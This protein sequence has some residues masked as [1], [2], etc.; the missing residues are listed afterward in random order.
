MNYRRGLTDVT[1]H[2]VRHSVAMGCLI[3]QRLCGRLSTFLNLELPRISS[4]V[5]K[6]DI[7]TISFSWINPFQQS[8]VAAAERGGSNLNGCDDFRTEN[9]S[10]QG[11]NLVLTGLICSKF[12]RQRVSCI[13]F[14]QASPANTI[15]ASSSLLLSSLELG[16][17]Q[18]MSLND[19]PNTRM[20]D[21]DL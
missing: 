4:K 18:S 15:N 9:C 20:L 3:L 2:D 7:C 16:D 8:G 13:V 1:I 14:M 12:D 11:Q 21:C 6:V 17:T 10:S 19:K 5:D